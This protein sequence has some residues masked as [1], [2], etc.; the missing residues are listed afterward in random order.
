MAAHLKY[1]VKGNVEELEQR[2]HRKVVPAPPPAALAR[3][4][5]KGRGLVRSIWLPQCRAGTL[6]VEERKAIAL[7]DQCLERKASQV[8]RGG[9]I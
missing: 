6:G 4:N 5:L 2:F 8:Y 1:K 7:E 9:K 3:N